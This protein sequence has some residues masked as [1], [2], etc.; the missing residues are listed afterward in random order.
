MIKPW[1]L[2]SAVALS[3][4]LF[5]SCFSVADAA[6]KEK[7][8]FSR[9][10]VV[11]PPGPDEEVPKY[12]HAVFSMNPDGTDVQRI[13]TGPVAGV[14]LSPDG[15]KMVY[16][17]LEFDGNTYH[18]Y[19]YLSNL[20]GSNVQRL[21]EGF[22]PR[23]SYDGNKIVFLRNE[24]GIQ[25][26]WVMNA[27]GSNPVQV[28]HETEYASL[29]EPDLSPDGKT[30]VFSK[31]VMDPD[32]IFRSHIYSIH[33]DGTNLKQITNTGYSE[34]VARFSPD[35]KKLA[36]YSNKDAGSVFVMNPDGSNIKDITPV[37]NG[38]ITAD[39]I[40]SPDSKEIMFSEVNYDEAVPD[41]IWKVNA[42][43]SH[44][45]SLKYNEG[46]IS[47]IHWLKKLKD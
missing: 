42:D 22:S 44:V 30:I 29:E 37:K 46:T 40:W 32:G 33:V 28:T 12:D 8:I 47:L 23:F 6:S 26:I 43:G 31:E 2:I 39:I 34:R 3:A 4:T 14:E 41:T 9:N 45:E 21:A 13:A 1:K 19:I 25:N 17:N 18:Q 11:A 10:I 20:D 35:G 7:V 36:V 24:N 5:V 16:S 27:D 15:T 38:R